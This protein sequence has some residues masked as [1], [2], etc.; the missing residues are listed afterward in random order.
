MLKDIKV[1][2][3]KQQ[4]RRIIKEE[5]AQTAHTAASWWK[6]NE[7]RIDSVLDSIEHPDKDVIN[8]LIGLLYDEAYPEGY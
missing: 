3:T 4:L 8:T 6:A 2:I 5:S 7:S 1:K